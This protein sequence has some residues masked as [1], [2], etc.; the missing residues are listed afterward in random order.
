MYKCLIVKSNKKTLQT[1]SVK[2]KTYNSLKHLDNLLKSRFSNEERNQIL[3]QLDTFG[4]ALMQKGRIEYIFARLRCRR[5]LAVRQ[6]WKHIA[7]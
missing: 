6:R 2:T 5:A 7:N 1:T 3:E 4:K